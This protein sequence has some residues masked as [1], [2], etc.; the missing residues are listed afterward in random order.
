[1]KQD[2]WDRRV[3]LVEHTGAAALTS[4]RERSVFP[5]DHPQHILPPS[6]WLSPKAK[7]VVKDSDLI[8]SFD[9]V[10]LNGLFLQ[11]SKKTSE[12]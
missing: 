3:A 7:E 10:D 9:W 12:T 6:Y 4:I 11:I 1:R 2:A 8:V 5:T